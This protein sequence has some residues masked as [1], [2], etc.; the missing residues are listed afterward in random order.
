MCPLKWILSVD[1]TKFNCRRYKI[2]PGLYPDPNWVD[3]PQTFQS[4]PPPFFN[5]LHEVFPGLKVLYCFLKY[6]F[7]KYILK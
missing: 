5:D 7:K 4:P 6:F 2:E 1:V 3:V